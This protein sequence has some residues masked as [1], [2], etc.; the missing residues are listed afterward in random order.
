MNP[1]YSLK[2]IKQG[3]TQKV[4]IV[5]PGAGIQGQALTVQ[6][7]DATRLQLSDIV[8]LS[9][10]EKLQ[11]KRVG[12]DLQIALPGGDVD[13][14]DIVV[15][16]YYLAKDVTLQGQSLAGEWKV[17]KA[18]DLPEL[19]SGAEGLGT[20]S[21]ASAPNPWFTNTSA[22]AVALS[23]VG[24]SASLGWGT[25]T[26]MGVGGAALVSSGKG[27]GNG[28]PT[29]STGAADATPASTGL[30]A[31]K[32]YANAN[33]GAG[34]PAATLANYS[35]AG[36]KILANLAETTATGDIASN[37]MTTAIGAARWQSALNSALDKLDGNVLTAANVQDMANS[38][39]RILSEA[40][41]DPAVAVDVYPN[42]TTNVASR[43][44][45][46]NVGAT[47]GN[48]KSID[49]LNDYIGRVDKS[50][51]DTVD[52]INTVAKA[53]YNVM[54]LAGVAAATGTT[55][56][57]A[58]STTDGNAEWIAGLNT[59]LGLN[60]TNGVNATNV[61]GFKAGIAGH[62]DGVAV[63]SVVELLSLL[64][65]SRLQ[66]FANDTG[67]YFASAATNTKTVSLP[68]LDDWSQYDTGLTA[69]TSLLDHTPVALNQA[70]YWKTTNATNGLMA[71][72]SAL[73]GTTG[74]V[75]VSNLQAVVDS[76]GR[77]LQEADG[78]RLID[79]DVSKV[80]VASGTA[81]TGADV[82]K[83]DFVNVGVTGSLISDDHV[84]TLLASSV[85]VLAST[86]V[87]TLAELNTLAGYA[88]NVIKQASATNA[89]SSTVTYADSD[90]LSALSG[91]GVTGATASN[92]GAI[93]S[94]IAESDDT[95]A[96]VDTWD[97]LQGLVSV[98][99]LNDYAALNTNYATPTLA[100]YQAI[101]ANKLGASHY[102]DAKAAYLAS[103]NSAID[104]QS[105][106]LP[107][108]P[109]T[110][111]ASADV[112]TALQ[113]V[114]DMVTQYNA[115][116][117][118]ADGNRYNTAASL[119]SANY[120]SISSSIALN[121]TSGTE[122]NLLN[123]VINGLTSDKVD[124]I[125]ELITLTT[126]VNKVVA[127]ANGSS[128]SITRTELASLGLTA[129]GQA[130]H[131]FLDWNSYTGSYWVTDSEMNRFIGVTS[132]PGSLLNVTP[133]KVA[134]WQDL[135]NLLTQAVINA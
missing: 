94:I 16:D 17:Y 43:A 96:G 131:G 54:L 63:D 97:E 113:S 19:P 64:S 57:A 133:A 14:P 12:K 105:S 110:S 135:Q 65:Q 111:Y 92:I 45:F 70:T 67:N 35:E 23:D 121:N 29:P 104:F 60:T 84:A 95:G 46:T 85:G 37:T 134:S 10:P 69:N 48:D 7:Q 20:T 34:V 106:V 2:V 62:P 39:F 47:V 130:G 88:Q 115:L 114:S 22:Q 78:S 123:S 107:N 76:Y 28:N 86:S 75:S 100:D 99:R 81:L 24:A 80:A 83:A 79:T 32:K 109:N 40:D 77:I 55:V 13:A 90:W 26:A 82:V 117:N 93:K 89:A 30:E 126:A 74:T 118:S 41:N 25:L 21:S 61:V 124:Q 120:L 91:L 58:Y 8:T 112:A 116:L 73:D 56:P 122:V 27:G 129:D 66:T 101:L 132:G 44:D 102:S 51:V 50:A 3:Q 68:T 38:Y 36:I 125:S 128:Q 18:A 9:A 108:M 127:L 49:L 6:A 103:Y 42:A 53:T 33:A 98:V 5:T 15:K 52:E 31:L 4:H 11:M 72:N 119:T 87:D 1:K 59:L 71:L